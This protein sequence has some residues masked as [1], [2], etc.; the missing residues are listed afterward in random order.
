MA[1]PA[2]PIYV[3]NNLQKLFICHVPTYKKHLCAI[4]IFVVHKMETFTILFTISDV[5]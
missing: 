2:M 1:L 3:Y 4:L 5:F